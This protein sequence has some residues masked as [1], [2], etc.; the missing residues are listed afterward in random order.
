MT[1]CTVTAYGFDGPRI[2]A[3][4]VTPAEAKRIRDEITA[5]PF[6]QGAE[7]TETKRAAV[8]AGRD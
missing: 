4:G 5:D 3:E 2:V 1:T 6:T 8:A 7:I